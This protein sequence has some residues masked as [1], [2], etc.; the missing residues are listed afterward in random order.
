MIYGATVVLRKGY[1]NDN[2]WPD[3]AAHSC[4]VVFLL[5]AIANFLWQQPRLPQD[6]ETPLEK[7]WNVSGDDRAQTIP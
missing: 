3:I 2:F 1:R 5:G 4:T 6:S 7:G